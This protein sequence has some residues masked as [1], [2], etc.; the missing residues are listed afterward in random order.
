LTNIFPHLFVLFSHWRITLTIALRVWFAAILS[1][2]RYFTKVLVA[3]LVPKSSPLPLVPFLVLIELVRTLIQP[4]T[5]SIRLAVN[6]TVG[7]LIIEILAFPS[8]EFRVFTQLIILILEILVAVV[9]GYIFS[10]L[11]T[12]Y[13]TP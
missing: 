9:Q 13:F 12:L 4:L 5:L 8:I 7:H 11:T 10:L 3:G 1:K 2:I 6:L